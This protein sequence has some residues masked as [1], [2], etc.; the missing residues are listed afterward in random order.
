MAKEIG[1]SGCVNCRYFE[2][3]P[4]DLGPG[5]PMLAHC[6]YLHEG[7]PVIDPKI[8]CLNFRDKIPEYIKRWEERLV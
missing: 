6:K 3:T 5:R 2:L 1:M 7:D 8:G 4:E